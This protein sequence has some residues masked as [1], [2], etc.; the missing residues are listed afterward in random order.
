MNPL[1]KVIPFK[2]LFFT[3]ILVLLPLSIV[4]GLSSFLYVTHKQIVHKAEI[5]VSNLAWVL[6]SRVA[7]D[8]S[9]LESLLLYVNSEFDPEQIQRL[10][11]QERSWLS[12]R[13]VHLSLLHSFPGLAGV[14]IFDSTGNLLLSSQTDIPLFSIADRPHFLALRNNP[15]LSQIF[16][17]A[18]IARSTG[19]WSLALL[20]ASRNEKGE[21]TGVVSGLLNLEELEKLFLGLNLGPAGLTLLRRSDT[22]ALMQRIPHVP[23]EEIN[24][25]LPQEN[26]IRQRITA[27]EDQ[28]TL[29]YT[30]SRDSQR[31][32]GSVRVLEK[33]PFYVQVAL[34]ENDYLADWRRQAT[35]VS[36]IS[37]FVLVFFAVLLHRLH[38]SNAAASSAQIAMLEAGQRTELA[39]HGGDLG[40]WDWHIP[41]GRVIFNERWCSM[42]GYSCEAI[43][44]SIES[45]SA[46]VHPEDW[47]IINASLDPHLRGETPHYKCEHRMRHNKGHW[48]WIL[49]RG[50]VVERDARGNPVRAVGTHMDISDRKRAEQALAESEERLRILFDIF[51]DG[52][53][54]ID[55][56][57][58]LPTT[59]NPL[60]HQQLGYA[61]EEFSRMRISDYEA[62]E[63]AGAT[64]ARIQR[65]I[66]QGR[67]DFET[68]HRRKDGSLMP[69][70]VTALVVNFHGSTSFL[71]VMRNMTQRKEIE[72]ALKQGIQRLNEAQRIAKVGSWEVDLPS[73]KLI[74]SDELFRIFEISPHQ[75]DI[76]Y[77]A[78]IQVIH[79]EDR[80]TVRCAYRAFLKDKENHVLNYR[81]LFADGRIKHVHEQCESQCDVMG[82]PIV[83]F[84][85]VQDVTERVHAEE[86]KHFQLSF[87][88]LVAEA[89]AFFTS[90]AN[91]EELDQALN[92]VLQDLGE[93][94]QMDRSY[95]F[96]F[97]EDLQWMD[98]THEWCAEGIP[99]QKHRAQQY[100]TA[101][102]P[103]WL[104]HIQQGEALHLPD[105]DLL[106]P[107]AE[108][109]QQEFKAQGIRSLL[110]LPTISTQ[111]LLSGFIGFDAVQ[112][113]YCWQDEHILMLQLVANTIG[114]TIAR[115]QAEAA[116]L[117]R[118]AQYRSLIHNIPGIAFRCLWDQEWTMIYMSLDVDSISGYP[119][120]DILHNAVRS[121][122]SIIAPQDRNWVAYHVE[123]SILQ[124]KPWEIE[125]RICAKDGTVH[126]VCERGQ[127]IRDDAGNVLYLD[128]FI[129]D[130]TTRKQ[131]EMEVQR[132]SK[133]LALILNSATEGIYGIDTQGRTVFINEAGAS[134][135]GWTPEEL[136]GKVQHYI[137]HHT[138]TD[139]RPYPIEECP[140]HRTLEDGQIREITNDIFWHQDHSSFPVEYMVSPVLDADG[141]IN[142]SM[143][144]FRN[145]S[146]R[147]ALMN[148]LARSNAELEQFSYSI[149]HDLRQ[150]LRMVSN[151]LQLL[152]MELG[153]DLSAEH[154]EYIDFA[155]SGAKRLDTMMLGL[156]E[157]SR[158]GRLGEP[159]TWIESRTVLAEALLFLKPAIDEAEALIQVE[160]DW[161]LL[162]V[163]PDEFLRLLQNLVSN[164][165]KFRL[166]DKEITIRLI[167]Q[168]AVHQWTLRVEDNGIGIAPHQIQR[169]F[170]VFQR[171]QSRSEYEGTGLGLALCRKIVE[172]HGGKISVHSPGEGQG[173]CFMVELPLPE[174]TEQ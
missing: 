129:Y 67:E 13:L 161:P 156:L 105:V 145:L 27:G 63:D 64:A 143:V 39:L 138:K 168:L 97:S 159:A 117:A 100:A 22:F 18:I 37:L 28:F 136:I 42:L 172:H 83:L 158:I 86:K 30:A 77:E 14:N 93:L 127:S 113:K 85:T 94:F 148:D 4:L 71:C 66:E 96:R 132:V 82:N 102:M 2:S 11:P 162:H 51:P 123:E 164:A 80:E 125:Y 165:L 92:M 74:G 146:E 79:P 47:P 141:S 98:N 65:I 55:P 108:A 50:K 124:K 157:Y 87:Q 91:D 120:S 16:S 1:D 29:Y 90:V 24:K 154:K 33:F 133:R 52:I 17:P 95:L 99:S 101:K 128:G 7:S 10:N 6:E 118:E 19:K 34:T 43:Q 53:L 3:L 155:I 109:E 166:P 121:Y 76:S 70:Q 84:G 54:I 115:R 137:S 130:I 44:S 104:C 40:L 32:I 111:G 78:L 9:R 31:R 149:S 57:T 41:S 61:A 5:T 20:H 26:A 103:W 171:L 89:S 142:G 46:L 59:F 81:L 167:G 112:S 169:L 25:T 56:E 45:W 12:Q 144:V 35:W 173:S 131:A 122:A 8:L 114:G 106:P 58:A 68:L 147:M 15:N 151:F 72:L 38:K 153:P 140:V 60:A 135:L 75:L 23:E 150:P 152:V 170:Q 110:C 62:L 116:L 48:V 163:S 88:Q 69:V 107:E 174:E 134:M 139:G 21:F 160:G 49:D 73:N 36:G 119:A 126:W